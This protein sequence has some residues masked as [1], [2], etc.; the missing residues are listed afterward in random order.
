MQPKVIPLTP[1]PWSF[2]HLNNS[3]NCPHKFAEVTLLKNY[4]DDGEGNEWG[5]WAHK[6][7]E[8][9]YRPPYQPWHEN[10]LPYVPHIER[11]VE[12]AGAG[13]K[14]VE[15]KM[16]LS[17]QLIA[18]DFFGKDVWARSV[19]DF[20]VVDYDN[21]LA[22]AIDWKFGKM[23]PDL[24]QL[25]LFALFV[26]YHYPRVNTVETSFEWMQDGKNT[27]QTFERSD[28]PQLWREFLPELVE[29][30]KLFKD[31]VF[32]KRPSGLCRGYCP[33]QTCEH[34]AQKK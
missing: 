15:V 7:I 28:M 12:W 34:W 3:R 13:M 27:R 17:R 33:V 23:K 5:K 22:R 14:F 9:R 11:A 18:T 6:Q 30:K 2:S 4:S 24:R 25:R 16:G 26:F 32:P 29:F 31:G 20:L 1:I 21:A 8:L 10:M 19:L